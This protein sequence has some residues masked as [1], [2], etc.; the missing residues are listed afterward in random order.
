[1]DDALPAVDCADW[2]KTGGGHACHHEGQSCS[3]ESQTVLLSRY[4]LLGVGKETR[5]RDHLI[6]TLHREAGASLPHVVVTHNATM[7]I[8]LSVEDAARLA[9][10]LLTLAEKAR[11]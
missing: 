7:M 9:V 2:C 3:S 5:A 6:G 11:P 8:D 4:P 10:V 1:M